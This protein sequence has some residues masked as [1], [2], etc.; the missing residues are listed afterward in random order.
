[1]VESPVLHCPDDQ[2]AHSEKL[3]LGC[4]GDLLR[5]QLKTGG[6]A[7]VIETESSEI[8][9]GVI[10]AVKDWELGAPQL[11]YSSFR[12]IPASFFSLMVTPLQKFTRV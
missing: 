1:M 9:R 2:Q 11:P 7:G 4:P 10:R 5:V 8:T 3:F 6:P 12:P